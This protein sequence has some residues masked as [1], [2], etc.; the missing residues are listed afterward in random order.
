MFFEKLPPCPIG[1]E[2]CA[3]SHYWSRELQAFGHYRAINAAGL[4]EALR[5]TAEERYG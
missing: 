2:A 3:S 5:Q 4:R 1:I